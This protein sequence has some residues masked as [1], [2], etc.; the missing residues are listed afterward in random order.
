TATKLPSLFQRRRFPASL[1][2]RLNHDMD[3]PFKGLICMPTNT[4]GIVKDNSVL[5]LLENSLAD[6]VLYRFRD[7]ATGEGDAEM[8]LKIIKSFWAAVKE[9]FTDAWGLPPRRS[10]LMHGAGIVS[11]GFIM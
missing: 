7:S 10:R 5:K 9:V 8:M 2:D 4:T 3:S 1:S 6:G 11:L